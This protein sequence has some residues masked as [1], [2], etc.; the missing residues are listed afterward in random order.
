MRRS[1]RATEA[2][3]LRR[4]HAD[5]V[6]PSMNSIAM[7]GSPSCSPTSKMRTMFSCS[8]T[9]AAFASCMKRRRISSL[10]MPSWRSLMAPVRPPMLGSRARRSV[11]MPPEP[12]E[13]R[14]S[15][16]PMIWGIATDG[17]NYMSGPTS[18]PKGPPASG[19]EV[20]VLP[21]VAAKDGHGAGAQPLLQ[22][23]GVDPAEIDVPAHVAAAGRERGVARE[24]VEVGRR[25][26]DAAAHATADREHHAALAVIGALG[27]VLGDAPPELGELEQRGLV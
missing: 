27:A 23:L 15:Y 9:P 3:S 1:L 22:D 6:S 5:S 20:H 21:V 10:S 25:A 24:R 8:S 7:N 2:G 16:R 12:I 4:I 13:P 26:V 19:D 17:P 11:P 18:D 14:I